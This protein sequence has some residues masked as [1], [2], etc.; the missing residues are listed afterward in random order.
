MYR[1]TAEARNNALD[2]LLQ[3]NTGD[4]GTEL[5]ARLRIMVSA[6]TRLETANAE[7][8]ALMKANRAVGIDEERDA[9]NEL[10]AARHE[11]AMACTAIVH[12][13]DALR[14]LAEA[15][16]LVDSDIPF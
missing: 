1:R 6:T 4:M 7:R 9:N 8:V 5:R 14:A 11:I 2:V 3:P 16:N 13:L 15:L 10:A 12:H